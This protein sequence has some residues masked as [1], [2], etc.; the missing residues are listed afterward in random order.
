MRSFPCGFVAGTDNPGLYS[1][2]ATGDTALLQI[3][4]HLLL[5]KIQCTTQSLSTEALLSCASPVEGSETPPPFFVPLH[6]G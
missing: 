2:Q 1:S 5:R 6:S 4:S 3:V